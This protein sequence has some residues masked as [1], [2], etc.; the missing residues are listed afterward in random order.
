MKIGNIEVYGIIYKITNKINGKCYIGQT[1]RG[2]N[3][4]YPY[5]GS[6]IE[7]VYKYHKTFKEKGYKYNDHLLKSIE[8]YG[9]NCWDVIEIQ[10]IA[11]SKTELDIKEIM[12]IKLFNCIESGYNFTKGGEGNK[13]CNSFE[14]KTKEEMDII[15]K[16]ISD[17]VSGENNPMYGKDWREGKTEEELLEHS[18]KISESLRGRKITFSEEHN[19]KISKTLKEKNK[20]K[21]EDNPFYGVHRK[22]KDNPRAKSV[23]CL[24]TSKIFHTAKEGADYYG[25]KR[26]SQICSC[27]RGE[28]KTSG[29][30]KGEKLIWRFIIWKHNKRYRI[31]GVE[32]E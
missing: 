15:G 18:R 5:S 32:Y 3:K 17:K 1:T 7:K 29:K 21:G 26:G 11:F 23:I 24:T 16:K 8:R 13:G 10:D 6:K 25:I 27:C 4:R 31:K 22:G 2:F 20:W 9:F 28:S 30:Y 12:Y 19:K 14:N